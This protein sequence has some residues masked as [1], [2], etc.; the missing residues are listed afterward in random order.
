MININDIFKINWEIE[1]PPYGTDLKEWFWFFISYTFLFNS[2]FLNQ[3]NK[4]IPENLQNIYVLVK[5][6]FF[7]QKF[8]IFEK[9][10]LCKVIAFN[11]ACIEDN[12]KY[13]AI[14]FY[15]IYQIY[16]LSNTHEFITNIGIEKSHINK[17]NYNI[18]YIKEKMHSIL[19]I[20]EQMIKT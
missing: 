16:E 20:S 11:I 10:D 7:Y 14:M 8:S 9:D 6:Y 12:S 1:H 15:I 13:K 3:Q 19:F 4:L 5:L 2:K 17:I 18:N